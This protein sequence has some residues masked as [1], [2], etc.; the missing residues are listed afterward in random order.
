MGM[1]FTGY[2]TPEFHHTDDM[3]LFGDELYRNNTK[4]GSRYIESL[5]MDQFLFVKNNFRVYKDTF[6]YSDFTDMVEAFIRLDKSVPV[7]VAIIDE[8]QD[9]TTLQWKMIWSAFRHCERVYIAGDDDQAIYEWSGADVEYFL[10]LSGTTHVLS[11]SYRLPNN[12]VNFAKR[13]TRNIQ[14]RATK[15]YTGL[16]HKGDLDLANSL[17]ELRIKPDETYMILSRNNSFLKTA[18]TWVQRQ[19]I[20][21]L[22]KGDPVIKPSHIADIRFYEEKRK[23]RVIDDEDEAR[24]K[25]LLKEDTNYGKP[26][27]DVFRWDQPLIDYIRTMIASKATNLF[28]PLVNISTIHSVK[29]GEAD[30]VILL[31]DITRNV[32]INRDINPDSEHRVFYVGI[33]R[34]KKSLRIVL[35][36]T[37]YSYT[38]S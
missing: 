37:K 19:G 25:K 33:T 14:R 15:D 30:H 32:H 2:Y 35:P 9:L 6:G 7:K 3:Y 10:S 12:L 28:N 26:W 29:G 23:S 18:E 1:H 27:Y 22:Y 21:Y 34:A 31:S 38:F 5:N 4:A 36:Q 17:D 24:L 11:H 16:D 20:P 8:A 13:V